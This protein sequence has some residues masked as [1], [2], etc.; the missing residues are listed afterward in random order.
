MKAISVLQLPAHDSGAAKA[1]WTRSELVDEMREPGL[2]QQV[3]DLGHGAA[4]AQADE[5]ADGAG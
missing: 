2:R 5:G 1:P 3:D 4:L